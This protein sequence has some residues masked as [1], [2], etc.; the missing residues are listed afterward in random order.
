MCCENR[1]VE[2]D[3]RTHGHLFL[4]AGSRSAS[5]AARCGPGCFEAVGL[6]TAGIQNP[7]MQRLGAGTGARGA[8]LETPDGSLALESWV[9]FVNIWIATALVAGPGL[10]IEKET[11][12]WFGRCNL[13][14]GP[15]LPDGAIRYRLSKN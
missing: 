3:K 8:S 5:G 4:L 15:I 1:R 14:D 9:R 2:G 10:G 12:S 6:V 13:F 11:H 7:C